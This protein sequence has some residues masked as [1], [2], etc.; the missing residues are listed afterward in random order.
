M[1]KEE[2]N[3]ILFDFNSCGN[4]CGNKVQTYL[5]KKLIEDGAD[6]NLKDSEGYT[7][8]HCASA[9]NNIELAEYL[10]LKGANINAK[11]T[12]NFNNGK[13]PLHI[14]VVEEYKEMVELLIKNGAD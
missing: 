10:I 12:G 5:I 11:I 13:T 2:L 1:N 4:C 6:I 8:L 9:N 7:S 14:A 3:K